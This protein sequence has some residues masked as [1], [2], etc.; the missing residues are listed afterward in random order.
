MKATT[1]LPAQRSLFCLAVTPCRIEHFVFP[2]ELIQGVRV[3]DPAT[4]EIAEMVLCGSI[5]KGIASSIKRA[6]GRALGLS[7][8]D[9]NLLMAKKLG[10]KIVDED[11]GEVKVKVKVVDCPPGA[12]CSVVTV[13]RE[14]HQFSTVFVLA[15]LTFDLL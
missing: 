5:N 7:G 12:A 8:K 6:G 14:E 13:E 9:D 10:K 3:S 2:N 11:T 15:G 1:S 4:V